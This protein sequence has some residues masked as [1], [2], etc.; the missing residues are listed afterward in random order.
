MQSIIEVP[1]DIKDFLVISDC[2]DFAEDRYMLT[3]ELKQI[4]K[5]IVETRKL[6]AEMRKMNLDYLNATLLYGPPGTGKT[7]FAKYLAYKLKMDF[8]FLNLANLV[9]GIMGS[10]SRNIT[11]VFDF[12]RDKKCIFMLDEL[13]CIAVQRGNESAATGGEMSRIT[14]T[15]MQQLDRYKES[16]VDCIILAATNRIEQVDTALQ[17]RFAIKR[18]MIPWSNEMKE[19]YISK[20]LRSLAID[21]TDESIHEYVVKNSRCQQREIEADM[22]RCIVEWIKNGRKDYRLE[23]IRIK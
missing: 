22:T 6:T 4:A 10:T 7:K 14:I 17:S 15:I 21:I 2:S 23:H 19:K 5:D 18:Q 9:D 3:P 13:D 8:A 12:I 11:K 1:D 16:K 20:F